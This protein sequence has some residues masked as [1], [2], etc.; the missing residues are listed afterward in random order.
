MAKKLG[1]QKVDTSAVLGRW[2]R[3]RIEKTKV[4]TGGASNFLQEADLF[5]DFRRGISKW[6]G[7]LQSLLREGVV[8]LDSQD[9]LSVR[10]RQRAGEVLDF[11]STQAWL[12]WLNEHQDELGPRK[13]G[14]AATPEA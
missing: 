9:G 6:G 8:E 4:T 12:D 10:H 13:G 3:A 5:I 11:D 2:V 7:L 1:L 14:D